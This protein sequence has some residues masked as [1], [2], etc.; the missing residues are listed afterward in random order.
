MKSTSAH[1]YQTLLIN[2]LFALQF[3]DTMSV[4]SAANAAMYNPLF[5]I[6][7]PLLLL[8]LLAWS[9]HPVFM[10]QRR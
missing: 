1:Y 6:C 10:T 8:N 7:A 4:G 3:Y 5:A 2:L 9:K